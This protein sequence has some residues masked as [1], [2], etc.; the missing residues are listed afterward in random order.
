MGQSEA[1]TCLRSHGKFEA[2]AGLRPGAASL[3]CFLALAASCR[4][5]MSVLFQG[6]MVPDASTMLSC[7]V[8]GSGPS[9]PSIK[10]LF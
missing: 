9:L 3:T 7:S 5:P 2:A 8:S 1:W 10:N 6:H 4:V